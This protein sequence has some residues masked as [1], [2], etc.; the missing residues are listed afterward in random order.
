MRERERLEDFRG[1]HVACRACKRLLFFSPDALEQPMLCCEIVYAPT[2]HQVDLVIY[3]R[4]HPDELAEL[5]AQ[6]MPSPGPLQVQATDD[7]VEY[8]DTHAP[9]GLMDEEREDAVSEADIDSMVATAVEIAERAPE[10]KA[11][12]H[13]RL[14]GNA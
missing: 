3:D 14:Q 12:L 4:L 1:G 7:A 8:L 10:R 6:V 11:S 13:R 5:G 9:P 2:K